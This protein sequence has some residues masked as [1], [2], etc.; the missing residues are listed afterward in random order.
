MSL[1]GAMLKYVREELS[2]LVGS[3]IEKIFQPSREEVVITFRKPNSSDRGAK[4]VIFSA[5]GS[6]ARVNL[7]EA[8]LENPPS[9]PMFCMLLRK[10]LGSGRLL[11]I[12]Q[13]GLERILYFDFECVNEIGDIVTN[14]LTAEI[15]GRFSNII[16]VR[17]GRVID[18]VKRVTDEISGVRRILPNIVYE[19]P[20]RLERVDFFT[21]NDR[22][23]SALIENKTERLA[24][25]LPAVLEGISPIFAREAAFYAAGDTDAAC[26]ELTDEQ[27]ERLDDFFENARKSACFTEIIDESGAKKDFS[28]VDVNQYGNGFAKRHFASANALLDDFYEKKSDRASQRARDMLKL[29]KSRAERTARKLELR[30]KELA[31]CAD[32]ENLRVCGD[33]VNAN[34]YRLE[35][36]MTSALLDDFYTGE[37]RKIALDARLTPAQNAQK[38]YS[39]YRKL[40][41]AEKMLTGLIAEGKSELS[42]YESLLD[43]VTRAKTDGELTEIKRELAE[44]GLIR[45]EKTLG[46]PKKSEPLKFRSS[47]GFTILVGKNNKQNDELTLKT[48]KASDIWLH[49]KDI[50]GSHVIIKTEGKTP[51]ERTIVEAARL[52]AYH[53]KAKNGSGVP[54]DYTAV[55]FVKKPAGARPGMV[56]FTDNRTLYVTPNEE[57][58]DRLK[59]TEDN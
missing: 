50:A 32:R 58:A 17:G 36:G 48:S 28:F 49:V 54:V 31:D 5:N 26:C 19:T 51:P 46:K 16:L 55:K 8:A 52:A 25:A 33:I 42:Y 57:E 20:P 22:K 3:R 29:I 23:I 9:P 53:S 41:T 10:H 45:G 18:S 11:G 44:Q 7:T 4:R 59:I 43:S 21:A 15:M 12:R 47:D 35:K 2:E 1:D 38:Y 27:K 6:S 24:K 14:T 40:C 56:I 39:E 30:K 13:D 34:I 37:Q